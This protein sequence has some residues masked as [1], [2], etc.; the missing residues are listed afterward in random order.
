MANFLVT[1]LLMP[2]LAVAAGWWLGRA[3]PRRLWKL[4]IVASVSTG[5]AYAAAFIVQLLILGLVSGSSP[6][7]LA[8]DD[9]AEIAVVGTALMLLFTTL[10]CLVSKL[11]R[12]P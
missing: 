4:A 3:Y 11:G 8:L 1:P 5:I 2:A 10:G 7:T 12:K 6:Q 9:A